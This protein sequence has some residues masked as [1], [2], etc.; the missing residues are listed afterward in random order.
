MQWYTA[1]YVGYREIPRRAVSVYVHSIWADEAHKAE[2]V[3]REAL[4]RSVGPGVVFECVRMVDGKL[5]PL[6]ELS[7]EG[8]KATISES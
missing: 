4:I 8:I 3:G 7:M 5:E 6:A 1:I 2:R